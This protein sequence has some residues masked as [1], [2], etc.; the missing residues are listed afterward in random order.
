MYGTRQGGAPT[1]HMSI[2]GQVVD[3]DDRR[4]YKCQNRTIAV[5]PKQ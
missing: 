4:A 5:I 2:T 1:A 3:Y